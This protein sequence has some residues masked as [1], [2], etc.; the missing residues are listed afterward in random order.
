MV[1]AERAIHVIYEDPLCFTISEI[2]TIV[3]NI[4]QEI[5]EH[6]VPIFQHYK[7]A[8][9]LLHYKY[10]IKSVTMIAFAIYLQHRI[11]RPTL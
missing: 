3:K 6:K 10:M 7:P 4:N 1:D 9:H 2:D 11:F 8:S 5:H